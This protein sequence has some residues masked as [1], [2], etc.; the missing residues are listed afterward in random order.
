M[1][2]C[3][4][5]QQPYRRYQTNG[6]IKNGLLIEVFAE[7]KGTDDITAFVEQKSRQQCRL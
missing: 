7:K 3:T 2:V 4:G 1:Y 5:V 6:S